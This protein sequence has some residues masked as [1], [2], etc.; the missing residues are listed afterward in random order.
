MTRLRAA[1]VIVTSVPLQILY[2]TG[3]LEVFSSA[4]RF[5]PAVTYRTQVVTTT[6]GSVLA[7][8]GLSRLDRALFEVVQPRGHVD[9]GRRSRH[10]RGRRGHRAAGPGATPRRDSHAR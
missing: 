8:C 2:V 1:V 4:S 10:G 5:L 3:P 7:S 6:G 9:G